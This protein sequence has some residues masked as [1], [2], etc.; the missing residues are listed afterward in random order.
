MA[1]GAPAAGVSPPTAGAVAGA[2]SARMHG[3]VMASSSHTLSIT[4]AMLK[5]RSCLIMP[6]VLLMPG[7]GR[8]L[9]CASPSIDPAFKLPV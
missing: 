2:S 5:A 3:A 8:S 1:A 4:L 6:F 7:A 9:R